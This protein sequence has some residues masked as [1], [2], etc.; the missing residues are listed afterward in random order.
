MSRRDISPS[1]QTVLQVIV[2]HYACLPADDKAFV[3]LMRGKKSVTIILGIKVAFCCDRH[4]IESVII[5]L[6]YFFPTKFR[7]HL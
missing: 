5:N 4:F 2:R 6:L 1:C 7:L 3:L